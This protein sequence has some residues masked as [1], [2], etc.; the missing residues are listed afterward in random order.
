MQKLQAQ[1]ELVETFCYKR[2]SKKESLFTRVIEKTIHRMPHLKKKH[3][4]SSISSKIDVNTYSISQWL[5]L[6]LP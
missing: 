1:K 3:G 6:G 5:P 4:T 2:E